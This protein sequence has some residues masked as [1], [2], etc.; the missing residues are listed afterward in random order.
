MGKTVRLGPGS[1]GDQKALGALLDRALRG[2]GQAL[3]VLANDHDGNLDPLSIDGFDPVGRHGG[4]L[5]L[6]EGTGAGGRDE[7]AYTPP[8]ALFAGDDLFRY[9]AGDGTGLQTKGYARLR[10]AAPGLVGY[11]TLDELNERGVS[12]GT[13]QIVFDRSGRNNHGFLGGKL[14]K[15]PQ[16]PERVV[17]DAP[18]VPALGGNEVP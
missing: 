6:S 16:A 4:T 11:W 12:S 14:V 5:V 3:D 13:T 17:S 7:L 9:F 2:D 15:V 10:V 18:I 8:P 1:N